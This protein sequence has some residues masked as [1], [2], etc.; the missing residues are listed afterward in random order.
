MIYEVN[1][2]RIDRQLRYLEKCIQVLEQARVEEMNQVVEFAVARAVHLAVECMIDV[3]SVMI[4]GFIMRDPGG[5]LDI[6]DILE[7]EQVI[8][9]SLASR[10]KEKVHF[11]D[12]LVRYYDEL[13]KEDLEQYGQDT[14]TYRQF[15]QSVESYLEKE[16]ALG[17]IE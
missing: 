17:N 13:K 2:D 16:R 12:K 9:S 14:E 8:D 7:D 15:I 3:G 10:I 4:D 1:T 11:R 6:V 5:Y